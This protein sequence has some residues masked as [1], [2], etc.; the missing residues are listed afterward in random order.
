[1]TEMENKEVY[2]AGISGHYYLFTLYPLHADLPDTGAIYI[3]IKADNGFYDALHI[4]ETDKLGSHLLLYD[5]WMCMNIWFANGV[6]VHFEDDS[7]CRL[8]I[9]HDL[10]QRQEPICNDLL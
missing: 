6:C 2:F 5:K 7:A 1:M 8:K 10:I 4:G 3:Y 9:V